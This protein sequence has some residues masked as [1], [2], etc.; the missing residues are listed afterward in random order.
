MDP[1]LE[2]AFGKKQ[3]AKKQVISLQTNAKAKK[4]KMK[5]MTR[6]GKFHI[7][8]NLLYLTNFNISD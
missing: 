7:F 1:T 3:A 6:K 8:Y 4:N 2:S 5:Q